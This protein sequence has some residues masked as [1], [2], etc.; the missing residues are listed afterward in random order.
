M[1]HRNGLF[2]GCGCC[3]TTPTHERLHRRQLNEQDREHGNERRQEHQRTE[4]HFAARLGLQ[5]AVELSLIRFSGASFAAAH[6][7][8]DALELSLVRVGGGVVRRPFEARALVRARLDW[9]A[10]DRAGL[11]RRVLEARSVWVARRQRH[12]DEPVHF[13][14]GIEVYEASPFDRGPARRGSRTAAPPVPDDLDLFVR[15]DER[16]ERGDELPGRN[17]VTGDD[18]QASGRRRFERRFD[19]IKPDWIGTRLR[20]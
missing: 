19:V 6:E 11:R 14:R 17:G 7:L 9:S 15:A 3:R 4:S 8:Q 20:H 1:R 10:L 18:A 12:D 13:H 16:L 5:D 2:G